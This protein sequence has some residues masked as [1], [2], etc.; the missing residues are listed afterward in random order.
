MS[1]VG[2]LDQWNVKSGKNHSIRW[3]KIDISGNM[4]H[5]IMSA[6]KLFREEHSV[7]CA[8]L[9][10]KLF[11]EEHFGSF[12]NCSVRNICWAISKIVPRGTLIE[13]ARPVPVPRETFSDAR[14]E[15]HRNLA[16]LSHR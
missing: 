8:K 12:T 9:F 7:N 3:S 6:Y 16:L 5:D 4:K 10:G 11:R 15:L 13:P 2:L 14:K 1:K